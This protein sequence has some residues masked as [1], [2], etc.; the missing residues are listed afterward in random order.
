MNLFNGESK[1]PEHVY[2]GVQ[3]DCQLAAEQFKDQPVQGIPLVNKPAQSIP[4]VLLAL[5]DLPLS[6][7]G[8]TLTLPI[9]LSDWLH[10][11]TAD[12][13]TAILQPA[14]PPPPS[15]HPNIW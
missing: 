2:G 7:L 11:L 6:A 13:P 15:E 1:G 12:R 4:L 14:M 10:E 3:M 8:D 5:F 9:V